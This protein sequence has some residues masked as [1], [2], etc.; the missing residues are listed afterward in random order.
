MLWSH[1]LTGFQDLVNKDESK[2]RASEILRKQGDFF[3]VLIHQS[4]LD[5]KKSNRRSRRFWFC[6]IK[7]ASPV[8]IIRMTPISTLLDS[9]Q[10]SLSYSEKS[11][12]LHLMESEK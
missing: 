6:E 8:L 7:M 5:S 3:R 10:W 9:A 4:C 12:K 11:R 1:T 2:M